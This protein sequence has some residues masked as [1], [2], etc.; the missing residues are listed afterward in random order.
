MINDEFVTLENSNRR[1]VEYDRMIEFKVGRYV[2]GK[3][4]KEHT[5]KFVWLD[6]RRVNMDL[7]ACD[8]TWDR[9]HRSR[10]ATHTPYSLHSLH[11]F[12]GTL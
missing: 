6:W 9:R 3:K 11:R 4:C 5:C 7:A 8:V 1:M 12:C 10:R 2:R